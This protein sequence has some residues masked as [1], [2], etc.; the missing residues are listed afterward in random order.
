MKLE[1]AARKAI[2]LLK[3]AGENGINNVELAQ[4]LK[5]PKRRIY[6]IVNPLK[7]AGLIEVKKE[8]GKTKIF[9]LG[10]EKEVTEHE[11]KGNSEKEKVRLK[12][13]TVKLVDDK[14]LLEPVAGD[15]GEDLFKFNCKALRISCTTPLKTCRVYHDGFEVVVETDGEGLIVRPDTLKPKSPKIKTVF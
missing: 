4:K 6:D 1:E 3:E 13:E 8:K 7:P 5:G 15:Q 2:E 12:I 9:W 14:Q 10:R 11:T